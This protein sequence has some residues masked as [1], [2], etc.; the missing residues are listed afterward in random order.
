[1]PKMPA[2][3]EHKIQPDKNNLS[4]LQHQ[5]PKHQ[6]NHDYKMKSKIEIEEKIKQIK[7]Q[8]GKVK[9]MKSEKSEAWLRGYWT[10]LSW[11]IEDEK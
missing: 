11:T 9:Q 8:I 5:N 6:Q 3:M 7:E 10:G 2:P 1:M 4:F